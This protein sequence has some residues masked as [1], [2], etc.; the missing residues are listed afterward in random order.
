ML[1][2]LRK[3]F[4]A[5]CRSPVPIVTQKGVATAVI[6]T[7]SIA[8]KLRAFGDKLAGRPREKRL[9]PQHLPELTEEHESRLVAR[10]Q[11]LEPSRTISPDVSIIIAAYNVSGYLP[12][13]VRSAADQTLR[14]VEIL[15]VDDHSTDGTLEAAVKLAEEDAR[16]R[17]LRTPENSGGPG[18]PR[19]IGIREARA[20]YFTFLDGD[21][22]LD[23]HAC[24]VM[25][26]Q[27]E[28]SSADLVV[29]RTER[30]HVMTAKA[31]QWYG[32]L[33]SE[34][35]DS[36][37]IEDFPDLFDDTIAAGKLY[38]RSFTVDADNW[39]LEGVHYEDLVFTARAYAEA[40]S[41]SIVPATTY[42]WHV[43]PE[44]ERKSITAQ[45]GDLK[46]LEHRLSALELV[47]SAIEA[48]AGPLM[49]EQVKRKFLKHDARIY[50]NQALIADDDWLYAVC[51]MLQP[52]LEQLSAADWELVD[53]WQHLVYGSVLSRNLDGIRQAIQFTT[54]SSVTAG[55]LV[56][57]AGRV[58]WQPAGV[59][60]QIPDGDSVSASLLDVTDE[61]V[62]ELPDLAVRPRYTITEI[63]A[64]GDIAFIEGTTDAIGFDPEAF[65]KQYLTA[66][67]RRFRT[68]LT[69]PIAY[70]GSELGLYQWRTALRLPPNV[71]AVRPQ[72]WD[73][74][75][76]SEGK[77]FNTSSQVLVPPHVV[78][79]SSPMT[80]LNLS[81]RIFKRQLQFYS[82]GRGHLAMK[83]AAATGTLRAA[84]KASAGTAVL[85]RRAYYKARP[86]VRRF[87]ADRAFG[88]LQRLPVQPKA[89]FCESMLG[90][91]QWDSPRYVAE[92]L[93]AK[94][95]DL[96][97][98]WTYRGVA[99][100]LPGGFVP[101]ERWSLS[102]VY[103][104]AT[105]KYL[106]DN[107]SLPA[108][109]SKRNEQRYL[110]TWHGIPVKTMGLDSPEI[111]YAFP[112]VQRAHV[113]RA[114]QWDG[115]VSPNPYFEQT[116]AR[117]Y[118]Y[119]GHVV[120]YGTPRND[121]LVTHADRREEFKQRL[122]LPLD[123]TVVLYAPTFRNVRGAVN[124]R[125]PRD[126]INLP[127]WIRKR[128][129]DSYLLVR[130]HYLDKVHI[131]LASS[132]FALDVSRYPNV[133]DLYLAAD[134]LV[135]DYSSVMFDFATLGR[136]IVLFPYDYEQYS[137]S[138]RGTYFDLLD[139]APGPVVYNFDELSDLI[140][141]YSPGSTID[142][143]SAET[144]RAYEQ[145]V[146]SFCGRETGTA[147]S[148]AA[149]FL[150][151][152]E[153]GAYVNYQT[154]TST[155]GVIS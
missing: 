82:T 155:T 66:R 92:Q 135:T 117:S 20:P 54:R 146:E 73:F 8:G 32:H 30:F 118:R 116:F 113:S 96:T 59:P 85:A 17:V 10:I 100:D 78:R 83:M 55:R 126:E 41:I 64:I 110:Q 152:G 34:A 31:H 105:S 106:I 2:H 25:W 26:E 40:E 127:D 125:I 44:D 50:L 77:P 151:T 23:P 28:L 75:V 88:A 81:G 98:Y 121:V 91:S 114:S 148:A 65:D 19:N 49:K 56:P 97:V 24:K 139:N 6:I 47:D 90:G 36:I 84:D 12:D 154:D 15:I 137:G 107:Q 132:P 102:Y 48:T 140:G 43:Y 37:T 42:F 129:R 150:L 18:V 70:I 112:E 39:L 153:T 63:N 149:D 123:R 71:P 103:R 57:H 14:N 35:R 7:K 120:R 104:A 11:S 111:K 29:G 60:E 80:P 122:G 101:V 109:F 93:L 89:V 138:E 79:G 141:Q 3:L 147:A 22:T 133:N 9:A 52:R 95:P 45:R 61:A 21:D 27:A 128:G 74:A 130:A 145:F 53:V 16:V 115:L 58:Y 67:L 69:T 134:V 33:F 124:P 38:R 143:E 94:S 136:P 4:L 144:A 86:I 142:K 108:F 68:T 99:P 62:T 131:P 51:D 87:A 72:I 46:N 119:R 76:T 5:Q 13:A 1:L